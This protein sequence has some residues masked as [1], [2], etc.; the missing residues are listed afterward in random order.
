MKKLLTFLLGGALVL[1]LVPTSYA[2]TSGLT[3]EFTAYNESQ[4]VPASQSVIKAGDVVTFRMRATN[5]T[6]TPLE[7]YVMRVYVGDILPRMKI[8]DNGVGGLLRGDYLEF[9]AMTLGICA[10][11]DNSNFFKVRFLEDC[12]EPKMRVTY[13]DKNVYLTL[14]K[15]ACPVEPTKTGPE[16]TLLLLVA[17]LGTTG[18]YLYRR[19]VARTSA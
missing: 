18:M 10:N 3:A 16:A 9:P 8:I 7:N 13:E 1:S 17:L 4:Q 2:A 5:T 12:Y 15:T 11:C 6:S 14:D 19:R